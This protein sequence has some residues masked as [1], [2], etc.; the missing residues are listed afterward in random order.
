MMSQSIPLKPVF[1][2]LYLSD[3]PFTGRPYPWDAGAYPSLLLSTCVVF[4]TTLINRRSTHVSPRYCAFLTWYLNSQFSSPFLI[5]SS[6]SVSAL[7]SQPLLLPRYLSAA[8]SSLVARSSDL[9]T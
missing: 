3:S 7:A 1:P 9:L 8:C 6:D 4:Y 5:I 2:F